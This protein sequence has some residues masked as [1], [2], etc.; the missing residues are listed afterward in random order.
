MQASIEQLGLGM[1]ACQLRDAGR[2]SVLTRAHQHVNDIQLLMQV[3]K[4]RTLRSISLWLGGNR[5]RDWSAIVLCRT[6]LPKPP[7][8]WFGLCGAASHLESACVDMTHNEITMDG[9]L[10]LEAF[11]RRCKRGCIKFFPHTA[12]GFV[13]ES[14]AA[15][16]EICTP[17]LPV[18]PVST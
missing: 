3:L 8:M 5:L 18:S 13:V 2:G 9:I 11:N 7:H 16:S 6:I 10:R 17:C 4:I 1:Q 15:N 14:P 12:G